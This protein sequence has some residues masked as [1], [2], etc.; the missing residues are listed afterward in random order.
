[1]SDFYMKVLLPDGSY[2]DGGVDYTG[3]PARL[4]LDRLD[5]MGAAVLDGACNDGFWAFW[6]EQQGAEHVFAIDVDSFEGYDWGKTEEDRRSRD[7][8]EGKSKPLNWQMA[9]AGFWKIHRAW[10]SKV[11][12]ETMSVYQLSP[13]EHGR[14][15]VIF[16]FGLLY[17]LR[18]PLKALEAM[19]AVCRGALVLETHIVQVNHH[20]PLSLFYWDDA[21][22]AQTNW[23]GP[24]EA[25]LVSWLKSVG[26][27]H[28]CAQRPR[29]NLKNG[30]EIFVA[31]TDDGLLGHFSGHDFIY[32]DIAYFDK[33]KRAVREYV[34]E[35]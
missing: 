3:F 19:Y 6:A 25:A 34:G 1:M 12:R 33:M 30:R 5:L 9:G 24:T 16:C 18:H 8:L 31:L 7:T 15:D 20:L 35:G 21:F 11:R 22:R 10:K 13:E 27:A 23:V 17:H 4:G 28:V 26:F 14:Y 29:A 32:F 2:T